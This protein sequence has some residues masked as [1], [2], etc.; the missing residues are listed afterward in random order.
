MFRVV[1][2]LLLFLFSSA[3]LFAQAV[4]PQ[5]NTVRI[6]EFLATNVN[7]I[8]DEDNSHEGWIEI[9]NYTLQTTNPPSA[10]HNPSG[11]ATLTGC[12]LSDGTTEFPIPTMDLG[13]D[14]RII[15]WASGKD[16]RVVTAPLHT[17]FKLQ[18]GGGTL[19]LTGTINSVTTTLSS[20]TYPAQQPDVSWGRSET[21][22][23]VPPVVAEVEGF[24]TQPTPGDR[25]NYVGLGVA[26]KVMFDQSSRAY[27]GT[28]SVTLSQVTPDPDA[29]IR[30]TLDRSLPSP[31][32]PPPATTFIY[33]APINVTGTQQIRARVVKPGLLPGETET[34]CY[35]Q[36]GNSTATFSSTMPIL[37]LTNFAKGQPPDV[38]DQYTYLWVWEPAEP[39][40]RA[41]FTNTPTL[42]SRTVVDRRGSSTL[43]NPKYNLNMELRKARDDDDRNFP[44][45]GMPS[46]SD[47]VLGAPYEYDRSD[48]HNTFAYALSR[49]IGRYAP[50]IKPAEVFIDVNGGALDMT[51]GQSGDYFGIYEVT[52]KIRRD[53]NRVDVTP[54]KT[55]DN[56]PVAKTGGFIYKVDRLD[57]GDGGFFAGGQSMA[58]YYPK[59][60]EVK[61]PQRDPQEQYLSSYITSFNSALQNVN[62]KDPVTGYAAWIDVPEAIDHHLL[63]VWPLN[64][65]AFRL[66][67]YWHK[68]RGGKLIPGPVWDYDRTMFST[69]GRDGFAT[70]WRS[71][72]SDFGT[73]FFNYTWWNRM[74]Q[75]ID[76]YQK[77]I[78][79]WQELRRGALS[80]DSVNAL[81]DSLNALI[82]PEAITRDV[83]RWNKP[84]RAWSDYS[85]PPKTYPAGQ[86]AEVQRIKDFMQR[87]AEFMD[88]PRDPIPTNPQP[89]W[90]A[91]V[92]A[93]IP[94]GNV[95]SGTQVTFTGP[96]N[97]AAATI[98]YTLNGADPR[99]TGGGPPSAGVLTYDGTPITITETTRLRARAYDPSW[100]ALTGANNPPLVSKWSGLTNIRYAVDPQVAIGQLAVTELSYHPT[101]AT[102]SE[103]AINP[104]FQDRDFEFVELRNV[105]TT[106]IDLGGAKFT[107]GIQFSF[108]G[109]DA[110]SVPPGGYVVVVSNPSAFAARYGTSIP[111]LGP[112]TGDLANEGEELV[113]RAADDSTL[114]DFT[115]SDSWYDDSDGT[116]ASLEFI[117]T[118]FTSADFNNPANY[119]VGSEVNGTPGGAG[120]GVDGRVVINEI[121]TNSTLPLVDAIELY[122]P[123]ANPV[124][125]SNWYISDSGRAESTDAYKQFKIPPGTVIG[126]GEYLV[127]TEKDF[128][129]NGG[130]AGEF[131]FDADHG[132]DAFLIEA[133]ATG[134]LIRFVDHVE[135]GAARADESWGRWPNGTGL[136]YPM[137]QRTLLDET[138]PDN[139]Q[140]LGAPNSVPRFGPLLITEIQHT[141]D[142]DNLNLEFVEIYNPT[143]NDQPLADWGVHGDVD[144]DFTTEVLP[145]GGTL[146]V[147]GFDPADTAKVD[148]FRAFYHLPATATL[149]LAGPWELED[150]L[151]PNGH[152]VLYR[153]EAPPVGDPTFHPQTLEDET[154]YLNGETWPVATDGHS[155]GRVQPA[156]VGDVAASWDAVVPNPGRPFNTAPETLVDN[157][158]VPFSGSALTLDVRANDTDADSDI[159]VITQVSAPAHGT[160]TTDGSQISYS[161][162][163][164]YNGTDT[165]TYT[166]D[167]GFGGTTV[168]TVILRNAAP[169]AVKDVLHLPVSGGDLVLDV[170]ANDSD[171]DG[172][173]RVVISV[174]SPIN[175]TAVTDG[176]SITYTPGVSYHGTDEFTYTISDGYG[177]TSTGTV[178]LVNTAPV[179]AND[180][181][182]SGGQPVTVTVLGNDADADLDPLTIV[183]TTNGAGGTVAIQGSSITYTP[184]AGYTGDDVF[185]YTIADGYGGA[186]T[187][188]VTV[189]AESTF[190]RTAAITGTA[191]PGAGPG[192]SFTSMQVPSIGDDL[193][194]AWL[195]N[196]SSASV[197]KKTLL[198]AGNPATA[199]FGNGD[200]IPGSSGLV[201]TKL[202][203]PVCDDAGRVVYLAGFAGPA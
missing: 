89:Q 135:F 34:Q 76:F 162:D 9:W 195:A 17:N 110:V 200:A 10:I 18:P 169:A 132:D 80:K 173:P 66:S 148:A 178:Q 69:D 45:L 182:N 50:R 102:A 122:N 74:F 164:S 168:G 167:D 176:T 180:S 134:K 31:I 118:S 104:V 27:T 46:H 97:S 193:I 60:V 61:S 82:S 184:G 88:G 22:L 25:N 58:Y 189:Q 103:L 100:T 85:T 191:V 151:I 153:G 175:G 105:G 133:D 84:K 188:S 90:I 143:L 126:P 8:V 67:G 114:L 165:F 183:N 131:A 154:T 1:P 174:G 75:D 166:L 68:E 44:L 4:Q 2:L 139:P 98:Y 146:V 63:N 48:L 203:T 36:L 124:D 163:S 43:G 190:T 5:F 51:T 16:R 99:P 156:D 185:S 119:R 28:L 54:L 24:Y 201:F 19:T 78:D 92:N 41:R 57:T 199:L 64:L 157:L 77:Y 11:K 62:F 130:G 94:G 125:V 128:N 123:T 38:E 47:W 111:V 149:M 144:F 171:A 15:I 192:M 197:R 96:I 33:T 55:Y 71:P 115:Y 39:D 13:P 196:A 35:L 113:I 65:D 12:K 23:K 159:L 52:E 117:G 59:E 177:G 136:L 30:Y 53:K 121:L 95:A 198:I 87:R 26:G 145:A 194:T 106:T 170:S 37:V 72:V 40:N 138:L 160:A 86:A 101:G 83:A 147:V 141:P 120:I 129:P 108:S 142:G 112:W 81:L 187:A 116:G 155:L 6:T 21:D 32:S 179:A 202:G 109:L 70:R 7:G 42:V 56:G 172:D 29:E 73:D 79:R 186:A 150:R 158:H 3:P 20:F 49:S 107:S 93:S 161:P 181:V 137:V 140:P 152:V 14:E 127:L 91:P